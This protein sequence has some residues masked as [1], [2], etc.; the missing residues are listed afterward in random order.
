MN[1]SAVTPVERGLTPR[2][3]GTYPVLELRDASKSFGHVVALNQVNLSV[4]AGE[5]L[6]VVGDNGAGKSTLVKVISGVHR[7]DM[8]ELLVHGSRISPGHPTEARA[9]GISTVFQDLAL[10]ET[11]DVA[12]NMF[13]GRQ[14]SRWGVF[15]NRRR[16]IA[17][18]EKTLRTYQGNVP[19]VRVAVGELSGGQRQSVAIARAIRENNPIVL[20]DE[21]TAALGVQETA[22]VGSIINSLRAEGKAVVIVSHDLGFVFEHC[23][24]IQVMRLGRS[25]ATR[26]VRDTTRE[27][28]IGLITGAVPGDDTRDHRPR[29]GS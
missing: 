4:H 29:S 27:G 3:T 13:L 26:D 2:S 9:Q 7:P 20:M 24:R 5:V 18:A 23:D 28:V 1:T 21:P 17:E 14:I 15:A 11:L 12:A 19:S 10:V 25:S 6:A 8:G 22:R 16:M